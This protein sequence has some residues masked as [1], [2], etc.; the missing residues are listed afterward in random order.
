MIKPKYTTTTPFWHRAC[1]FVLTVSTTCSPAF[2]AAAPPTIPGFYGTVPGF[3]AKTSLPV[4]LPGGTLSGATVGTTVANTLTIN[5]TQAQATIDWKSFNIAPGSVV[6][7]N[8]KAPEPVKQ[9][10]GT[11][12]IEMVAQPQW[13]ALNRIYS[14]DPSQIFGS[15]KADGKV[16][17]INSNGILFG[18]GSV[19]NTRSLIASNLNIS[20]QNFENGKLRFTTEPYNGTLLN[21]AYVSN[22]GTI[23]TDSGG[24]VALI[25]P[26]VVNAGTIS[27]PSGKISLIG[28]WQKADGTS[29]E[30]ETAELTVDAAG[31]DV[32]YSDQLQVPGAAYNAVGGKLITESGGRINMYGATVQNDGLIRSVTAFKKGGVVILAARDKVTTGL[33]SKIELPIE[34][35]TET[36][37]PQ[38]VF[39]HPEVIIKGLYTDG[40]LNPDSLSLIDHQ[41]AIAAPSGNVTMT[42]RD[43]IFLGDSSSINVAGLSLDRPASAN[44]MEAQLNSVDLRDDYGQKSGPLL[45]QKVKVD[46]LTGSNIGNLK[47]NYLTMQTSAEER[48]TRG[49]SIIFSERTDDVALGQIIVKQGAQLDFSGGGIR[50][51]TG[52][53]ATSRLVSGNK[54]YDIGSAPQWLSYDR[55]ADSQTRAHQRFGV[56]EE[57]KGLYFGGGSSVQDLTAIRVVGSDAG[58]V[59]FNA[60]VAVLDGTLT[61]TVTRGQFQTN[62]TSNETKAKNDFNAADY[63]NYLISIKRG[64]EEPVGGSVTIGNALPAAPAA[65][66]RDNEKD[67]I[68]TAIAVR[69]ATPLREENL[70]ASSLLDQ[71]KT[72][73]IA[74]DLLNRAGLSALNLFANTTITTDVGTGINL[75]PGGS[76]IARSRRIDFGGTIDIPGGTVEMS[77]RPNASSY[78]TLSTKPA[79]YVNTIYQSVIEN[80]HLAP[81]SRIS[82]AGQQ[83]DNS[84]EGTFIHGVT[85]VAHTAGGSIL[86]QERTEQGTSTNVGTSSEGHSLVLAN[87]GLLDVSGGWLIDAKGKISGGN[88][89]TLE[90]KGP[91]LSLAGELRGYS[92]PGK[93]GGEIKLHAGEVTVAARDLV[94]PANMAVDDPVPDYLQGRLELGEHR[95]DDTGFSRISLTAINNI[96]FSDGAVLPPSLTKL[97]IPVPAIV[98]QGTKVGNA[99]IPA[100]SDPTV[101]EYIGPTGVTLIAGKNIYEN[102]PLGTGGDSINS[103]TA[104]IDLPT[105]TGI[106]VAPGGS[107]TLAE[108]YIDENG[109]PKYKPGAAIIAIAGSLEAPGGT[110]TVKA[111]QSLTVETGGEIFAGGYNK[112]VTLTV[113]GL[114]AGSSPQ[115]GGTVSLTSTGYITLEP[116]SKVDVSGSAPV[117]RLVSGADGTPVKV[118]VA[119]G[120]GTL[121][122]SYASTS[123]PDGSYS[124]NLTLDG[125]INGR[126]GINGS[127]GGN[128]SVTNSTADLKILAADINR[129]QSSGFDDLSFITTNTTKSLVFTEDLKDVTV[130]RHLTLDG[131]SIKGEQGVDVTLRS[132]WITVKNTPDSSKDPA[133]GAA[134]AGTA[135]LSLLAEG[136]GGA[137]GFLDVAGSI[138][139]DGFSDVTLQAGRDIRFSDLL[140]T[141]TSSFAGDLKVGGDLTLQAS[142]V[143]PTSITDFT[144]SSPGKV[145]VLPGASDL[146]PVYSTGGSLTITAA[147]GIEQ[148]GTLAA[149]LGNITLD[150]GTDGKVFLAEGNIITGGR[151]PV[152]YGSYNGSTWMT[153]SKILDD[154]SIENFGSYVTAAPTSSIILK[155]KEVI[156][157]QNASIDVSG[158]GSVFAPNFQ[159]GIPGTK[160]PLTIPGRYVILPDNSVKIPGNAVYLDAVPSLGL[161]AGIYSLL[162][163][164]SYAHI[165]GALVVQDA[166]MQLVAGQRALSTQGYQVVAG[167]GTVTDTAISTQA[168]KGYSIRSAAD[169]LKE[170]DFTDQRSFVA[171]NGGNLSLTATSAAL[172]GTLNA[173]SLQ[174][175]QGGVLTLSAKNVIAQS[176]AA[177][178]EVPTADTLIVNTASVK[179]FGEVALGSKEYDSTKNAYT[180]TAETVT[181]K[182]GSTLSASSVTLQAKNSVTVENGAVVEA[183]G[184][185]NGGVASVDVPA[186]ALYLNE[187]SLIHSKNDLRLNVGGMLLQ[188]D[189]KADNGSLSLTANNIVFANDTYVQP[190]DAN[191]VPQDVYLT[192]KNWSSTSTSST[193]L[194]SYSDLTLV[195][196]GDMLFQRNVDMKAKG[197]LTLDAGRYAAASDV[198]VSFA[199][200]SGKLILLNSGAAPVSSGI[201]NTS[202]LTFKG[203]GIDVSPVTKGIVFDQFRTVTLDSSGDVTLRGAGTVKVAQDLNINAARM[204][205]SFYKSDADPNDKTVVSIPYTAAAITVDAHN[206]NVVIAGN[207][208]TAG[209]TSTPGG[210]LEIMGASITVGDNSINPV[211]NS[212]NKYATVME[213]PSGQVKLTATGDIKVLD[214]AS[215]KATGSKSNAPMQTGVY[216]YSPG[217]TIALESASGAV[218]LAGGS[219]LDVQA[220]DQGD[221]GSIKLSAATGGVTISTMSGAIK[222]AAANGQGG[223]LAIDSATLAG[224]GG[225]DGLSTTQTSGG[226]NDK[227]NIRSRAENLLTLTKTLTG[228]EVV[229]A[230]DG[231]A[232][233]L[234]GTGTINVD[235]VK[236]G[237]AGGRV[238]LYTGTTLTL[239]N[240][241][242]ISAKGGV[243]ADGGTVM[244]SSSAA[245]KIAGNY[246]V[247]AIT[248]SKI[249]VTGGSGGTVAFRAYQL[250]GFTDVNM[251]P[252]SAG[253]I[254]GA[255][256]VSVEAARSYSGLTSI[257]D[258]TTYIN[259]ATTFMSNKSAIKSRLFGAAASPSHLQAGIE[260]SSAAGADLT[261]NNAWDLSLE[262]PGGEAGIVTL[263]AG[264]NLLINQNLNDASMPQATLYSDSMKDSWGINLI[265]GAGNARSAN[266]RAVETGAGDLNIASGKAVYTENAPI[267]FAAG[268]NVIMMGTTAATGPGYMINNDMKYNMGSYGGTVRGVVG[269]DLNLVKSGSAI[270]AALGNINIRVGGDLNLGL[271]PNSGAIR[272]T[273]EYDNS[274]QVETMPGSGVKVNTGTTSYWTYHNGGNITLDVAGS[275]AGNLSAANGWDGAY[276]DRSILANSNLRGTLPW[277]LAAGFGGS[278]ENNANTEIPVTVGIAAMGGGDI[279]VHTGSSLLTQIGAFGTR[280]VGNLNITSGGDLTGRF[281]VMNGTAALT[282]GGGFGKNDFVNNPTWRSVIEIADAQVSVVAQGDVNLGAVLN[283]DNSR[284]RLFPKESNQIKMWNMTYS[285]KS[286]ADINS[287]A[288]NTSFFG[289]DGY[290]AYT[291]LSGSNLELSNRQRI[292]PPTFILAAAG[293]L[294]ISNEFYLA[295]SNTGNLGLYAGGD[296]TGAY[297]TPGVGGA[298]PTDKIASFKMADVDVDSYY[299]RLVAQNSSK[300]SFDPGIGSSKEVNHLNDS[301]SVKV[302]AGNDIDTIKLVLNKKA[303][304]TTAKGDINSLDFIGQNND[305]ND[306]TIVSA[307]GNIDQG[308]KTIN[309]S[310]IK[311]GGP[312]TL[313]VE[314]GKDINLGNSKGIESIGNSFN[315]GF[316]G[317]NTDSAVIVSAGAEQR[318]V[319]TDAAS[320]A[321]SLAANYF[322]TLRQAGDDYSNLKAEGK[323][324][325][326]L[327]RIEE[328]RAEV[329]KYFSEPAEAG[330]YSDGGITMVDSLIRSKK[331][332]IYLMARSDVNVGRSNVSDSAQGKQDTGITTT[333]GGK[334]NIYSGRDLNVNESRTMTFMGGNIVIWSDQGNINAGRGS[335]TALSSGG[336]AEQIKDANGVLIGLLYPA[337]SVGSG[338]RASTYDP[339]G[340]TGPIVAPDPGDIYL[341]APKGIIDAG[342]AGIAGGKITLGATQVLNTK[343]ISFS[344]GSVGVPSGTDS[345][346]SLGALG[347]NSSMTDSSKMIETASSGG[348]TKDSAKQKLAQAADDFLSKFLDVRVIGFDLDT[349]PASDKDATEEQEKKKRKR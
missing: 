157:G 265:A 109:K 331:G 327:L 279:S 306:V 170:G 40:E 24:S 221:A 5:Q 102:S 217:G 277:Y 292:L 133:S 164:D 44:L 111:V 162:P 222:G 195:S 9:V 251:S 299:G 347:G 329:R 293:D 31:N 281:R 11:V 207:G 76:Y 189:F 324:D 15:L 275:V 183:L 284:D 98:S 208:G 124:E 166:G 70:D 16:Y 174:G 117:E 85:P 119:G 57:F 256:Q 146:N 307:H 192:E 305:I 61:S 294:N 107:I 18:A 178:S 89:G 99:I 147:G 182:N 332:D 204:T 188:G 248:G 245:D 54:L 142:R 66:N 246:A 104:R 269:N 91:T 291:N 349:L 59:L 257:G 232:I 14:A 163:A 187:N 176:G 96:N 179:G 69:Q 131:A 77:T 92:L 50:Y 201:V 319:P 135:N 264:N 136:S 205:T 240:G 67:S 165:S 314:A 270:Q 309:L 229:I 194:S 345:S 45:G 285:T 266:Y 35:S 320:G 130:G 241:S 110:V 250:P 17:L 51:G 49:G 105:G 255:S 63:Q 287:L 215:I 304:I 300:L 212:K 140:Y 318:M 127:R 149:P 180:Y 72:T 338:V 108:Q 21:D 79:D 181:V 343:N 132:P 160:N 286:S 186:G 282:S 95:L 184:G 336:S 81:G 84:A 139:M 235:G 236:N 125:E 325:E 116:G 214:N 115:P 113:A 233:A 177:L 161:K 88:A 337:P 8:Q 55:I 25:G 123:N 333:F 56:T 225:L 323:S 290:Y 64:L 315:S 239:E 278:N 90:L 200:D 283:P 296:L 197:T 112:P 259:D 68:V 60:R 47:N 39:N 321:T 268:N 28:A 58:S 158:G 53:M 213:S 41:G 209:T 238:E 230:A 38:F 20:D 198:N 335:K 120:P 7:F 237:E 134:T 3:T 258:S 23:T 302:S 138:R 46:V 303:E 103:T 42:A 83:I 247:Q 169:V 348:G 308:I 243:G 224:A 12:K 295:P 13:A 118:V 342:E 73:E 273:G 154:G 86:I 100:A 62:A 219:T 223:S 199:A 301:V 19:V 167:Y 151:V 94:F 344:A 310:E 156:V 276:I 193:K 218:T 312:G 210:S 114:P 274:K 330:L 346:V 26:N 122:I 211:D 141:K 171:G 206:G 168:Y 148:R 249:D 155:G 227:I 34:K 32:T 150:G 297:T 48:S 311:V 316:T 173:Q 10:D 244:L 317:E 254:T 252:L 260:I 159:S 22:Y 106:T 339:D 1:A 267:N 6:M 261:L 228:R 152:L 43:R 262:R 36:A 4:V 87:G 289:T 175:Y 128:L 216:S 288:G 172:N 143:Y 145:T 341:F 121:S 313:L 326:A 82:T 144:I 340:S 203:A 129:Y 126:A 65:Q 253:T 185:S 226:F 33:G 322:T 334:L 71:S 190:T 220:S 29:G 196:R 80:I 153:R 328:A 93:T 52:T 191:G 78:E 280:N 30:V 263:R 272:T 27:S 101:A 234:S 137:G 298:A 74:A 202:T 242:A 37:D 97:P 2:A 271:Q 75:L 231:G